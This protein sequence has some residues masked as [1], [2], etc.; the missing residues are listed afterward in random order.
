MCVRFSARWFRARA[1][2]SVKDG[3][4]ENDLEPVD[5]SGGVR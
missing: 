4:G 3:T 2:V 1:T 5:G